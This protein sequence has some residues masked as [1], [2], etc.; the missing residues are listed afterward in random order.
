MIIIISLNLYNDTYSNSHKTI[1]YS[2]Q[3]CMQWKHHTKC[4]K[5]LKSEKLVVCTSPCNCKT[6]CNLLCLYISAIKI[7]VR[8]KNII[9]NISAF[10][11]TT[12]IMSKCVWCACTIPSQHTIFDKLLFLSISTKQIWTQGVYSNYANF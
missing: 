4:N 2:L 6:T 12:I 1:W 7:Y 5:V 11:K 9:V 8:T 10:I 3:Q